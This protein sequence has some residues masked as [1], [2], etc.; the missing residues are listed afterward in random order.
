MELT[1][2]TDARFGFL[3]PDD[4]VLA[5][6][7]LQPG[8]EALFITSQDFEGVTLIGTP[9]ELRGFAAALDGFLKATL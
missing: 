2:A 8:Q 7:P 1:F 9:E 3:E 5:L 6:D 4:N